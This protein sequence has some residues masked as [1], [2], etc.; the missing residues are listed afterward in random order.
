MQV[1]TRCEF[2]LKTPIHAPNNWGFWGQNRGR[3]GA[4]LTPNEL[5][6]TFGGCFLCATFGK[7]RS[8][9]ATVR[10][11]TDTE[12]RITVHTETGTN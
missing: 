6:L 11:W 4:M 3:G 8:R 2:G 1:L 9:N 12:R 7:N 10:V 5:V